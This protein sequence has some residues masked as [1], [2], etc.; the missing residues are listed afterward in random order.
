VDEQRANPSVKGRARPIDRILSYFRAVNWA[1][2]VPA[3]ALVCNYGVNPLMGSLT[4][5]LLLSRCPLGKQFAF[6]VA[7]RLPG[8]T[9]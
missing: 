8:G 9:V 2:Q 3:L 1:R 7:V 6:L 4:R 5:R